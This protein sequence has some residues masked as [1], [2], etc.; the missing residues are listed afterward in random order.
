[1]HEWLRL[2]FFVSPLS[3]EALNGSFVIKA[4]FDGNRSWSQQIPALTYW[5]A[6]KIISLT[7]EHLLPTTLDNRQWRLASENSCGTQQSIDWSR[8]LVSIEV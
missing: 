4:S 3:A 7:C 8:S 2:S 6:C 1:M 5:D